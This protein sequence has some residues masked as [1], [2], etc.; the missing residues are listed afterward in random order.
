MNAEKTFFFALGDILKEMGLSQ[1]DARRKFKFD[2]KGPGYISRTGFLKLC[3]RPKQIKF[4]MLTLI[5]NA[6][7]LKPEDVIRKR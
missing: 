4:E 5:C 3:N 7:G 6:M 1:A 2:R